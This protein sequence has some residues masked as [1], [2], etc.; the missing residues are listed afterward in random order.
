MPEPLTIA[1]VGAIVLTEGVKFLYGQATELLK[2]WRDRREATAK[3][4]AA[5]AEA[6]A[7]VTLESPPVIEGKLAPPVIHFDVLERSEETLKDLRRALAEYADEVDPRPI[8]ATNEQLMEAADALRQLLEAV[9]Q[10]RITFK[11]ERRP[12]SGPV[13]EG[14]LKVDQL[15]GDAAAVR[16]RL[17]LGGHVRGQATAGTVGPGGRL[18]A[19]DV[20]TVGGAPP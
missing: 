6:A 2:R 3:G 1:A 12:S 11:G 7:R 16:A 20:D 14:E 8:D 17:V 13:V 10:Q 15:L 9:Y 19:V 18:S 5:A 4:D